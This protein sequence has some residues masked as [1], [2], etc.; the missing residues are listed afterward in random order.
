MHVA[1]G[2]GGG[3]QGAAFEDDYKGLT[4][5]SSPKSVSLRVRIPEKACPGS[6]LAVEIHDGPKG[7]DGRPM[8]VNLAEFSTLSSSF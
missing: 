6:I 1:R 2:G 7:E 3:G 4:G 8:Q 5:A